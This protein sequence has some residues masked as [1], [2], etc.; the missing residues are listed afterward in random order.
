MPT[1]NQEPSQVTDALNRL[2]VA[3]EQ[4]ETGSVRCI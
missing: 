3:M 2:S 1:S 4:R